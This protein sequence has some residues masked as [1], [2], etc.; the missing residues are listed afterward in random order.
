MRHEQLTVLDLFAGLGGFS[1]GLERA[2]MRTIA[3]SE[4]EPWACDTLRRHWPHVWNLGDVRRITGKH[5]RHVGREPRVIAAGFPC[6]DISVA[7]DGAGLDGERSGLWWETHRIIREVRPWI[8]ILENVSAL[9]GRGLGEVL[10]SLAEIGYDCE[11]HCIPASHLGAPHR[12][13]RVW[14]VA[15]ARGTRWQ[16]LEPFKGFPCFAGQEVAKSRDAFAGAWR[17]LE[18]D[19]SGL[20]NDDGLPIGME[21]R[22]LHALGNSIVPEFAYLIGRAI[23][24]RYEELRRAA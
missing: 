4:I 10:G 15:H 9:C 16:G 8:A 21:R 11:W 22:R 24:Q 1:L 13:D 20:R 2:G 6:Q 7:G 12:R 14:I 18:G 19:F 3:F 17:V 5:L 23:V